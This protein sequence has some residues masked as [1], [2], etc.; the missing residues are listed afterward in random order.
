MAEKK[1]FNINKYSKGE[2]HPREEEV[3]VPRLN[4]FFPE[5]ERPIFI[6]RGMTADEVARSNKAVANS[7]TINSLITAVS[8]QNSKEKT[9]AFKDMV[10]FGDDI[11]EDTCRKIEVIM[12][13][14]VNPSLPRE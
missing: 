5:G 9:K 13:G 12:I 10:G 8:S 4:S 2:F 14:L 1:G 6:V 11:A 7:K 3:L